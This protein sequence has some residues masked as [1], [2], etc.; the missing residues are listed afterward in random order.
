MHL[1]NFYLASV[2]AGEP[3]EAR[4]GG[5]RGQGRQANLVLVVERVGEGLSHQLVQTRHGLL[6]GRR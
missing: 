1:Y 6:V 5:E 3:R 2:S 4:E